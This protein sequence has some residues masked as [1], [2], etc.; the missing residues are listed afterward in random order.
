MAIGYHQK[1]YGQ[2]KVGPII[3][4]GLQE[5]FSEEASYL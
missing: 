4:I 2:N 1:K 5:D 3:M